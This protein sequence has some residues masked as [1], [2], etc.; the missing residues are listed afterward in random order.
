VCVCVCVCV[1]VEEMRPF[2]VV[3][4]AS[5]ASALRSSVFVLK[6]NLN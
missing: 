5:E 1:C 6:L 4:R 3:L 2:V